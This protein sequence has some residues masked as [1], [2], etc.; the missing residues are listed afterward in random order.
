V[1]FNGVNSSG[2]HELCE[3]NG[4]AAGTY[5]FAGIGDASVTGL[6]PFDLTGTT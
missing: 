3:T 6:N 2:E 5:E 4:T 1:L